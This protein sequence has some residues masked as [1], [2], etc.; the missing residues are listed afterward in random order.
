MVL[1]TFDGQR[2]AG[3][4]QRCFGGSFLQFL[5]YQLVLSAFNSEGLRPRAFGFAFF[6]EGIRKIQVFFM[7]VFVMG[8]FDG[9][10][11][12]RVS[13]RQMAVI[14]DLF[15]GEFDEIEVM[16]KHGVSRRVY[17]K[18]LGQKAFSDEIDFRIESARRQSRMIIAQSAPKAAD[19]L[20]SLANSGKGETARKACLDIISQQAVKDKGKEETNDVGEAISGETAARLLKSLAEA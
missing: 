15:A 16:Q 10:G 3:S 1:T 11:S 4:V 7:G 9:V 20:V 12:R 19:R 2:S 5:G 8:G 6:A 17:R 18:W 13:C 14:D